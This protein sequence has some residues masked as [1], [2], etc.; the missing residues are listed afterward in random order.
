MVM[1][2]AYQLHWLMSASANQPKL[3]IYWVQILSVQA[4]TSSLHTNASK[5]MLNFNLCYEYDF[6]S[7]KVHNLIWYF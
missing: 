1:M 6:S 4:I 3:I 5:I 7:H 2:D